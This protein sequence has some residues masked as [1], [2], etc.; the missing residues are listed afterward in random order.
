MRKK[1]FIGLSIF[2]FFF[3][4]FAVNY[5]TKSIQNYIK[6]YDWPSFNAWLYPFLFFF[7]GVLCGMILIRCLIQRPNLIEII[8]ASYG[9]LLLFF[10]LNNSLLLTTELIH[11]PQFAILTILL[12]N[13]F[14]EDAI[15]AVMWSAIACILDEW[16]Q[17]FTPN[18]VLDINDVFLN[19]S[20]LFLGVVFVWTLSLSKPPEKNDSSF[21]R[22]I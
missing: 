11:L 12:L 8:I 17:S 13:A 18:R 15:L 19:F 14:P 9:L 6:N 21:D 3:N 16:F 1:I 7:A 5:V 10:V 20:G 22:S 2:C 4:L